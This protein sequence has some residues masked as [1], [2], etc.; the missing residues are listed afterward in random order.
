VLAVSVVAS[1]AVLMV[2]LPSPSIAS[3][4]FEAAA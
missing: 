3:P 1:A 4:L 2:L